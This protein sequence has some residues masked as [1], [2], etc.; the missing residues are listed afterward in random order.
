MCVC[1]S[2]YTY[3][4]YE[5]KNNAL[6][7]LKLELQMVLNHQVGARG[8]TWM[9]YKSNKGPQLLIHLT[10]LEQYIF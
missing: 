2:Q 10:K 1:T 3:G 5:D 4:G 7:L 8:R 6:D 9:I